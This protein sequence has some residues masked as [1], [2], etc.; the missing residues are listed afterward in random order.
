MLLKNTEYKSIKVYPK[1]YS[2]PTSPS[3][4]TVHQPIR[5]LVSAIT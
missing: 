4:G 1:K 2:L 3:P 5:L